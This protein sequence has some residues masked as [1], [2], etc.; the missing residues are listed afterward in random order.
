MGKMN[1]KICQRLLVIN[2]YYAPDIASTGQYAAGICSGLV[3]RGFEVHVITGEPSYTT[4]SIETPSFEILDGVYIHRVSLG[5]V[6]G[7]ERLKTRLKG[8]LRFLWSAWWKAKEL[9]DSIHPDTVLTFH[10]PPFVATIGAYLASRYR[11]RFVYAPYDIHPDVLIIGGWDIPRA[12]IRIW[13]LINRWVFK[14]TDKVIVLARGAK[15]TLLN[16]GIPSKKIHVIP[17]WAIPEL[18]PMSPDSRIRQEFGIN[19]N[20]LLLLYA[21]NMGIMHP[22]EPI[23]E[24]AALLKGL[25]VHFLFVGGG[26]KKQ[27]LVSRVERENLSHVH[28]LPYQ[29]EP[30]FI[31]LLAASDACF[32]AFKPG[33]ERITVPSRAYTFL[34]A[35]KPLITIMAPEADIA[36]LVNEEECGWNVT[37]GQELA[38]LVRQ[39]LSNPQE[40]LYR[41]ERA[42]EVYEKQFQRERIIDE[43]AKVLRSNE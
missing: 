23:L 38:D 7:R 20:E 26:V 28:I 17:L 11:L 15:Q 21:G 40:I 5:G 30:R 42:R 18:Q 34:S 16:K 32:V 33:M 10:N 4:S 12:V 6:R 14:Q 13:D 41:G 39:L 22:I 9:V 2:Q 29:P 36:R 43:Y 8:Y 24:A 25:P 19:N 37:T 31:Q 35:G 27:Y 1:R 3:Q